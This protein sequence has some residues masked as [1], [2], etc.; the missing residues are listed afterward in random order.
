MDSFKVTL[1]EN[2]TYI[3]DEANGMT[4]KVEKDRMLNADDKGCVLETILFKEQTTFVS[5][6]SYIFEAVDQLN[7]P[8]KELA[9]PET[10]YGIVY[11]FFHSILNTS[12]FIKRIPKSSGLYR[13][14][15]LVPCTNGDIEVSNLY[16]LLSG[17]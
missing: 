8:V 11:F 3:T 9:Y 14:P 7:N 10:F 15:A 2:I 6:C 1:A 4:V 13:A 17:Y 12:Y 5:E 16:E